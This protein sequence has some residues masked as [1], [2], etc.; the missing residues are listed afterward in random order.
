MKSPLPDTF[1]PDPGIENR[2]ASED[3]IWLTEKAQTVL[4]QVDG[5]IAHYFERT[6]QL[7]EQQKTATLPN[8]DVQY[9]AQIRHTT[10]LFN[11]VCYWIPHVR[12]IEPAMKKQPEKNQFKKEQ[13]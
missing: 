8:G 2:I 9:Q 5:S 6:E 11:T 3:D 12:I 4:L 1:Q 13:P 7:P 10:Q